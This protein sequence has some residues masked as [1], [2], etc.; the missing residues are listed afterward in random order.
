M[1]GRVGSEPTS[2]KRA[3]PSAISRAARAFRAVESRDS[4]CCI[5]AREPGQARR[6]RP[7]TSRDPRSAA[8]SS[9]GARYERL[10]IQQI[11]DA[12]GVGKQTIYRWSPTKRELVAE[13]VL[14]GRV[15]PDDVGLEDT[16]DLRAD[17]CAWVRR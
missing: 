7:R 4:V 8:R 14:E 12:A 5:D 15:L 9:R 1:C 17:R 10:S 16:G 13:C 3:G 6:G 2:V 11:A